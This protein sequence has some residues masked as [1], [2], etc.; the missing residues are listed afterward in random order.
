M[1]RSSGRNLQ[2]KKCSV[3]PNGD[4]CRL[5][6]FLMEQLVSQPNV[7]HFPQ[8]SCDKFLEKW[9]VIVIVFIRNRF[10]IVRNG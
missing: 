10:T 1:S 8:L 2:A 6:S 7:L 4:V 3:T 9:T 5:H